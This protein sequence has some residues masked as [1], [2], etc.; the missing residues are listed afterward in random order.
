MLEP[1]MIVKIVSWWERYQF[2]AEAY[3]FVAKVVEVD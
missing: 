3:E 2:V 1:L